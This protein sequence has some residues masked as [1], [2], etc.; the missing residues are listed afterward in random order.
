MGKFAFMKLWNNGQ[1][2]Q[3][4]VEPNDSISSD[5][6]RD[7]VDTPPESYVKV[8]GQVNKAKVRSCTVQDRE[9]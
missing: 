2:I 9:M 7:I 8:T 5:D 4:V 6:V 3:V 1:T